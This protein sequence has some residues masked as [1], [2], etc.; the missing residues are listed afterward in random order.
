MRAHR[1]LS[2]IESIS[3]GFV[4]LKPEENILSS[5]YRQGNF[6][7]AEDSFLV[8]CMRGR[9]RTLRGRLVLIKI[10]KFALSKQ[11]KRRDDFLL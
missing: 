1:L 6:S 2:K 7:N 5:K 3:Y 10:T 9:K 8:T 11:W 4:F